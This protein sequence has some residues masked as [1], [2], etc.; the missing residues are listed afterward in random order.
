[1]DDTLQEQRKYFDGR[2]A[3]LSQVEDS[4]ARY[5]LEATLVFAENMAEFA[6]RSGLTRGKIIGLGL[7]ES[8]PD[9][10]NGMNKSSSRIQTSDLASFTSA[11]HYQQIC[12]ADSDAL[13]RFGLDYVDR[14]VMYNNLFNQEK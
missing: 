6:Y 12:R 4:E 5:K 10:I 7:E 11:E 8:M 13:L 2:L 1:M 3:E 14:W 9:I